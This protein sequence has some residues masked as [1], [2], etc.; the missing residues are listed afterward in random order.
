MNAALL[1]LAPW[2]LLAAA[3]IGGGW[4][5]RGVLADRATLAAQVEGLRASVAAWSAA[6]AE[7][8][9]DQAA[10]VAALTRAHQQTA[11]IIETRA[12]TLEAIK[13]AP[14]LDAALPAS[15]GALLD[16]LYAGPDDD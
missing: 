16:Q 15:A 13:D 9:A 11:R 12:A 14:D 5:G 4:W 3:L 7:Q 8:E 2:L 6:Y 1:R 10:V